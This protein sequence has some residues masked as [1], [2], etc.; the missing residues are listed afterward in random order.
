M[1]KKMI[2]TI[3]MI[4]FIMFIGNENIRG[5]SIYYA[6]HSSSNNIRDLE[7]V[8]LVDYLDSIPRS[9]VEGVRYDFDAMHLIGKDSIFLSDIMSI[10]ETKEYVYMDGNEKNYY[11]DQNFK[12]IKIVDFANN[13]ERID[14]S[15]V[16]ENQVKNEIY[17]NLKP[18]LQELENNKPLINLQ[19]IFNWIYK[20]RLS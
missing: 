5:N 9:T 4:M 13:M 6:K 19:W 3:C 2:I 16:N 12:L 14:I 17:K 18:V 1:I 20:D 10:E 15:T 11:F 7:L 8:M